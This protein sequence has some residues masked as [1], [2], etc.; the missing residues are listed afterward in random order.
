MSNIFYRC[1]CLIFFLIAT[2]GFLAELSGHGI[3]KGIAHFDKIAHFGIFAVL[4]LLLWKAFRLSY[5][6]ILVILGSYGAL[7][8]V[9]QHYFTRRSGDWLDWLA[10]MAGILF[11]FLGR[12]IWHRIRPRS[13]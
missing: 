5:I 11:F 3:G 8:E 10:D 7:V 13:R 4:S 6:A 1:S 12:A 2:T 9:V